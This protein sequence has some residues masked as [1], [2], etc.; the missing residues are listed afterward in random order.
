MR[1]EL[2]TCRAPRAG[3]MGSVIGEHALV[4]LVLEAVQAAGDAIERGG[5]RSGIETAPNPKM[6]ASL[7]AYCYARELYGSEEIEE[8]IA[9]PTMVRYLCAGDYPTFDMLRC[10]RRR[11]RDILLF[12]LGRVL[13]R[14]CNPASVTPA[15]GERSLLPTPGAWGMGSGLP[16]TASQTEAERRIQL[17]AQTDSMSLDD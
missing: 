10:F 13:E 3:D 11:H 5:S 4:A 9:E 8:Q 14:V 16:R 7:L 2:E 12:C 6:M 15:S 1:T 17:A